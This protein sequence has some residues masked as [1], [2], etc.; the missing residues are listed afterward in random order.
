MYSGYG[1][2]Y[3]DLTSCCWSGTILWWWLLLFWGILF[4]FLVSFMVIERAYGSILL[5]L[6]NLWFL[7]HS[8]VSEDLIESQSPDVWENRNYKLKK[9][10]LEL[11]KLLSPKRRSSEAVEAARQSALKRDLKLEEFPFGCEW[12][13][14]CFLKIEVV[15]I[16]LLFRGSENMNYQSWFN[17][18]NQLYV[19][20]FEIAIST[21]KKQSWELQILDCRYLLLFIYALKTRSM[22]WSVKTI[23]CPSYLHVFT[24]GIY[25]NLVYVDCHIL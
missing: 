4:F 21:R 8:S 19:S 1:Y 5:N 20:M 22:E 13:E 9:I 17:M 14:E 2:P 7:A 23:S 24:F 3:L 11:R 6:F 12:G 18:I 15:L 16:W 10:S 25:R